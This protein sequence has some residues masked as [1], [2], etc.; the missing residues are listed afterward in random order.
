[1]LEFKHEHANDKAYFDPIFPQMVEQGGIAAMLTNA[2][3]N[4]IKL[5]QPTQRR[6]D[7]CNN[8][9]TH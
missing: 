1:V 6:P 7:C 4:P 2:A 5:A 3:G 9:L 8:V